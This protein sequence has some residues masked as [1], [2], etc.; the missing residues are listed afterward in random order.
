MAATVITN[1]IKPVYIVGAVRTPVGKRGG[2]FAQVRA[3]DLLI[4]ALKGALRSVPSV[5]P[6]LIG[7]VIVGCAMPE[8]EQ[9]FNIARM[10]SVLANFPIG[11]SGVTVNRFCASGLQAISMAAD[12]IRL[13]ESELM[14]AAG[15][16]SMSHIPMG[17]NC[18]SLN[19]RIF[20]DQRQELAYSMGVTA[21]KVAQKWHV[22][23]EV[24]DEFAFASH[25]NALQAQSRGYFDDEI[26]GYDR[27]ISHYDGKTNSRKDIV[28]TITADEGPR[29]DTSLE[30]LAKL[31]PVFLQNGTVTAGNTSQMS[32]GAAALVL[33][34]ADMV[35]RLGLEP[36]ARFSGFHVAGVAPEYMGIGPAV[37]VPQL[38][39]RHNLK[40]ADLDWVELNEAFAA[41]SLAV[42]EELHLD[43]GQVNPYGGAIALGHPLGATGALRAVTLVHGLRRHNLR[44]GMVTMCIGSGMGAAGLF[45]VS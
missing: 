35:A 19:P 38:L 13:G 26:F 37:A 5:D 16:E 39:Q 40:I 24:Q 4:H 3:D 7:D 31:R 1:Q 15:V 36:L 2:V 23:R 42:M 41:Q 43:E 9:G 33:A 44:R 12:R 6:E 29:A 10:A 20:K 21:E 25:K 14:I 27:I 32:D 17:G 34:S 18:P 30:A 11:V 28:T 22:G 8:A 45:E